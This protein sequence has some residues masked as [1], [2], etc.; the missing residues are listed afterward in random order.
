MVLTNQPDEYLDFAADVRCSR[1]P[2]RKMMHTE[3]IV[4]PYGPGGIEKTCESQNCGRERFCKLY[5]TP[6]QMT[7][8]IVD[9]LNAHFN[10]EH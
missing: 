10:P 2:A 5:I 3:C 4:F 6:K 7:Q 9:S 1:E 8:K